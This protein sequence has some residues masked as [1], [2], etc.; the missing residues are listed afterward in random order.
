MAKQ[1]TT[2]HTTIPIT[3]SVYNRLPFLEDTDDND[4]LISNFILEIMAELNPCFKVDEANVGDEDFYTV[5]QKAC[6]ADF[7]AYYIILLYMASATG[8]T[9]E[10]GAGTG[11]TYM[12]NVKAG[13]VEV[14]WSAFSLKDGAAGF[15][16]SGET[17]LNFFLSS[18]I[19]KAAAMGCVITLNP[20]GSLETASDRMQAVMIG[21]FPVWKH[22][23]LIIPERG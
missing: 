10:S 19:R 20:D 5:A 18:G 12:S 11:T 1:Y 23:E 14:S 7:V 4:T 21:K 22:H 9:S 13:S 8:E 3:K 17:L 16:S 15:I 2:N 6:I